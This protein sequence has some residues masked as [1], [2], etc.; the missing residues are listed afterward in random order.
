M[1]NRST[2]FSDRR[3]RIRLQ[4]SASRSSKSLRFRVRGHTGDTRK[5]S[6]WLEK[7]G[8]SLSHLS[9]Y[10]NTAAM[11]IQISPSIIGTKPVEP[12]LSQAIRPPDDGVKP[13][14]PL[15][16]GDTSDAPRR[17]PTVT[18]PETN[19]MH[20][21]S[22]SSANPHTRGVYQ[23]SAEFPVD[24]H[25]S[26]G[27]NSLIIFFLHYLPCLRQ[28]PGPLGRTFIDYFYNSVS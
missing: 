18:T 8:S 14:C 21:P 5:R 9:G 1:G 3:G 11:E 2:N 27:R 20:Q 15:H 23:G 12:T 22:Q 28:Q 16:M 17:Q 13:D 10:P 7:P 4:D 19:S 24:L 6:Q 25:E 26:L